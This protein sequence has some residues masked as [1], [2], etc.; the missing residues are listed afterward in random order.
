MSFH[1][2]AFFSKTPGFL[3]FSHRLLACRTLAAARHNFCISCYL[4]YYNTEKARNQ[5]VLQG[6]VNFWI[7][8]EISL[9]L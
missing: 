2:P 8:I 7:D 1:Y 5:A 4:L 9:D 6:F 3:F